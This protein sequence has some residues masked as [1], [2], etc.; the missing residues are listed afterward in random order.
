MGD[1][2]EYDLSVK[3]GVSLLV[4][5]LGMEVGGGEWDVGEEIEYDLSVKKGDVLILLQ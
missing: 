5:S 4:S 1:E 2:I 3:K